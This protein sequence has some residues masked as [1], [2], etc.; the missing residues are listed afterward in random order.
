[1][2]KDYISKKERITLG[3]YLWILMIT[4]GIIRKTKGERYA[5]VV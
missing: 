2:R 3:W 5:S 4:D 1:M